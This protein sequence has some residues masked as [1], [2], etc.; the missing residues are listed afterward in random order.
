MKKQPSAPALATILVVDDELR[1]NDVIRDLLDMSG[2]SA[3]A[4]LTGEEALA[5]L[6]GQVPHV[7]QKFDLVL[8]D[9]MLPGMDGYEVCRRLKTNPA[10][11]TL[12]IIM[13]TAM[14]KIA[15]K[16]RGLDLGADD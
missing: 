10:T 3:E 6:T 13:L 1:V 4:A 14:G 9:I 2:Y 8:L 12:S 5:I 7:S 11:A 15:D 16:V